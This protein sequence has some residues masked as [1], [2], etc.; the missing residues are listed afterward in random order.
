MHKLPTHHSA[1]HLLCSYHHFISHMDTRMPTIHS[2]KRHTPVYTL[3]IHIHAFTIPLLS[4]PS[5]TI[6][7]KNAPK[8][9]RYKKALYQKVQID[10]VGMHFHQ[11]TLAQKPTK[12]RNWKLSSCQDRGT[13]VTKLINLLSTKGAS[14]HLLIT[15]M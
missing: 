5:H 11:S 3:H 8:Q 7:S 14:I 1:M 2:L 13:N 4:I 15:Y 12:H 10:H 9:E 6:S